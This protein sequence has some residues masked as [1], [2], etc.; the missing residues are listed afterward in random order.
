[1]STRLLLVEVWKHGYW[2]RSEGA[3]SSEVQP[4][5]YARLCSFAVCGWRRGLLERLQVRVFDAMR[6]SNI[7][8]RPTFDSS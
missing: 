2:H 4:P 8:I 3:T 7:A 1:M 5:V 6:C